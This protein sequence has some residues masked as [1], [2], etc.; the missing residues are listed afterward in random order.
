[1]NASSRFVAVAASALCAGTCATGAADAAGFPP[2]AAAARGVKVDVVAQG[3]ND[4]RGL[5]FGPGGLYVAEAG[6][7]VG[8][9]VPPPP[10]APV[11]PPTR[12]RC[13]VYW[14]VGPKTP[15]D[16]GRVTRI[17]HR[18]VARV[19]V[20]GLPSAAA[21][22]LIGGDRMGA[23][24]V[25]F[26]DGRL[27]VMVNGGGCAEGHPSE[28]NGLYRAL[29]DGAWSP[30]VDLG[31]LLRVTEDSKSPLDGDFEPD[32]T[33]FNLV[34][35]FGAF[36]TTEPNHGL[37]V[38]IDDDGTASVAADL[39]GAVRAQDGDGDYTYAALT[40]RGKY[41][42]VGTL[43]R[44][45]QDF[46]GAIYRVS[47]DGT[48]VTRVASGL[49]GVLGVAFDDR[50]R[51]YALETTA[52]GVAPPLSDPTAGRLV[53]IERDGSITPLVTGLAFPS[54]LVAGPDGAFYVS[55][56]GYHCDDLES[57]ESLGVGQVLRV[58]IRGVRAEWTD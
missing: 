58:T 13:E 23:A 10:P 32:G 29:G 38:R 3:L 24:A 4:P 25:A 57:G 53:R 1:M 35:A 27:Y 5:A 17:G 31:A 37:L 12:T 20:D 34:R 22:R 56:C 9:L 52:A 11:E 6:T 47:R 30:R 54:A 44:I 2:P 21:N 39:L 18:G 45:D 41:F 43:G 50:G 15:G 48:Q 36:W 40:R 26:R 7:T 16:T 28:P 42:Y 14:P 8:V 33:W 19:V 51:L 49:H 46:A 55:N